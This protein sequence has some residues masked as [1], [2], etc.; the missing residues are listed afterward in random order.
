M[1]SLFKSKHFKYVAVSSF[2]QL[3]SAIPIYGIANFYAGIQFSRK[4]DDTKKFEYPLDV[5][6][7]NPSI[8]QEVDTI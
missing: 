5:N 1:S 2:L 3:N 8:E 6:D 7:T 4:V